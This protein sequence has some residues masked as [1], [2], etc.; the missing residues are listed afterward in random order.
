MNVSFFKPKD[1][2]P[3]DWGQE[4]LVAHVP[5]LYTGKVLIMKAG[6]SGGL[7][8]HRKKDEWGYLYSGELLVEYDSGDGKLLQKKLV[9]GDCVHI[10]PEAVHRETAITDCVIFE[11]SNPV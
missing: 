10:P 9:A 1:V 5:G 2:A 4:I 11:V 7:Q 6:T 8:Y 3:R